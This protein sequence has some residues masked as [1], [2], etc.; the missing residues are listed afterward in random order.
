MNCRIVEKSA[1]DV[2]GKSRKFTEAEVES[3]SGIP[4]FW[5]EFMNDM[6]GNKVLVDMTRNRP[7]SVT[8]A[9][10]LGVS[11]CGAGME[12]FTY[13]IGAEA[14]AKAIPAGFGVVHVPAASWAVF[15]S[16]GPMPHAIQDVTKRIFSE[17]FPTTGYAHPEY[18]LEVYLPGDPSGKDYHC[19]VWIH[20]N[21]VF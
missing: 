12:E 19:Q 15:D 18:E 13:T 16:I 11:T 10:S 6:N 2:I 3:L 14:T 9:T 21:K 20:V 4:Q 8:G 17:W 1:F 7:G 5:D